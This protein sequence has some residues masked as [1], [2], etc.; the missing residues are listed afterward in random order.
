MLGWEMRREK[1]LWVIS[2]TSDDKIK[3]A[4]ASTAAKSQGGMAEDNVVLGRVGDDLKTA[5]LI[6]FVCCQSARRYEVTSARKHRDQPIPVPA[7]SLLPSKRT[8][9]H[10]RLSRG[11]I[12]IKESL[13][14]DDFKL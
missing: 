2:S 12:R 6:L 7:L 1:V 10:S 3:R 8:R 11:N 14:S 9:L 5:P 4:D 13:M